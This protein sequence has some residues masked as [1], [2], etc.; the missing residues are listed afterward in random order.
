[1]RGQEIFY[2]ERSKRNKFNKCIRAT[3]GTFFQ[4]KQNVFFPN[5]IF[6][7]TKMFVFI[8]NNKKNYKYVNIIEIPEFLLC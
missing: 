7:N 6:I 4:H 2:S 3:F 1:M 5:K 8:K